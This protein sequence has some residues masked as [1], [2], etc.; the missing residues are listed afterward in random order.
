[1]MLQFCE[2]IAKDNN[3]SEFMMNY[4]VNIFLIVMKITNEWNNHSIFCVTCELTILKFLMRHS[5]HR[6]HQCGH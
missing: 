2:T 5:F 3:K 4:T 6:L 1:M